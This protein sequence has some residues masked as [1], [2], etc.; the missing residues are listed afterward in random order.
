MYND[1]TSPVAAHYREQEKLISIDGVGSVTEITDRLRE[2]I[3]AIT[4]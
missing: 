2:A 3:D 1:E 4:G